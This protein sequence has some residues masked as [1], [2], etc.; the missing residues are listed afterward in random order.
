MTYLVLMLST[1]V[2]NNIPRFEQ[3]LQTYGLYVTERTENAEEETVEF[4]VTADILP[5]VRHLTNMAFDFFG[6]S[7]VSLRMEYKNSNKIIS[8]QSSKSKEALRN[9]EPKLPNDHP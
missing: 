7:V 5:E 1:R 9:S 2:R 6:E 8:T 4:V 3:F